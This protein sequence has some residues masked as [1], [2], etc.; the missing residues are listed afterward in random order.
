MEA[1]DADGLRGVVCG[2]RASASGVRW[3]VTILV[4]REAFGVALA[5]ADMVVVVGVVYSRYG[6]VV[7][8]VV[9]DYGV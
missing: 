5:E 7:V 3:R 4:L 9:D 1:V 6:D 2:N 8:V